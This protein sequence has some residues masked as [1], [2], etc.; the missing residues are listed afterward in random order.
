M[1]L[2]AAKDHR[3]TVELAVGDFQDILLIREA[4]PSTYNYRQ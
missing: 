2:Q 4:K 1:P 3:G